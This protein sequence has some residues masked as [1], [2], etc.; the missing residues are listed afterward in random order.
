MPLTSG[1]SLVEGT[2][3]G[4]VAPAG[5][6]VA[7]ETV[8]GEI[9]SE[10]VVLAETAVANADGSVN[11]TF[12]V[13]AGLPAGTHTLV[14]KGAAGGTYE[15]TGLTVGS[16]SNAPFLAD[17]NWFS[18]AAANPA[19]TAGLTAMV[20]GGLTLMVVGGGIYLSRRRKASKA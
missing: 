16:S 20:V 17:T 1:A 18:A 10:P 14:L 11:Y 3:Y 8:S 19:S 6:F 4:V 2:K 15:V 13:P 7:G 12:T 5:T 9:H